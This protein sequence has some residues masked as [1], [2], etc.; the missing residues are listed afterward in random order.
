MSEKSRLPFA[1]MHIHTTASDGSYS[2]TQIVDA[3]AAAGLSGIAI[4]DHDCTDGFAEAEEAGKRLGIRVLP[5]VE[6]S[7]DFVNNTHLLAF[8]PG[9]Y[10]PEFIDAIAE[11][12]RYRDERLPK[13]IAKL[14]EMGYPIS[15]EEI[16][17]QAGSGLTGRPHIAK[18]MVKKKYASSIQ[19]AF[20]KFLASSSPAYIQKK[21]FRPEDAISLIN[22]YNGVPVLAHPITMD[23]DLDLLEGQI[24]IWKG[25]GLKGLETLYS[26][27]TPDQQH[28]ITAMAER[29][30]LMKT[31]GT[32]FHGSSKPS[33]KLGWGKGD[34]R[35]PI[36][37]FDRVW[38]LA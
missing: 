19:E 9:G 18:A 13:I 17:E 23:F 34:L 29:L 7:L 2:P 32:D 3:A 8:F 26:E 10:N 11:L 5:G 30:D 37:L 36:E 12:K 16:R 28:Y 15:V 24:K 27:Y 35:I 22:K 14:C 1:D 33:I 25:L 4:T 21:K 6:I 20:D 31:G 38:D